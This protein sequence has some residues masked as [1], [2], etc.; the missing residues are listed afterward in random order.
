MAN[1]SGMPFPSSGDLLDPGTEPWSSAFQADS[2]PSEPPGKGRKE[3][4][5]VLLM[6]VPSKTANLKSMKNMKA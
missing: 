1:W 5:D 3:L 6:R 2:L 4:F